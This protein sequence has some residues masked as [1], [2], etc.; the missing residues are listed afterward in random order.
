[1]NNTSDPRQRR[2]RMV[3]LLASL[4]LLA[5]ACASVP[6][7]TA[8]MAV[9]EAALSHALSAGALEGA[10]TEMGQARDKMAR[11]RT[12]LSAGDHE[13]ALTLS[14]QAQADARLAEA[15][16]QAAKAEKAAAVLRED[17]RALREEMDRKAK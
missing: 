12:A 1:M 16:T 11:A 2:L 15:K 10:P 17:S 6:P 9:S 13:L 5:V 14:R 8:D 4:P 3:L 7:P